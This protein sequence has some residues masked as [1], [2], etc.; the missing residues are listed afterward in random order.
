[1]A[2][3]EGSVN[4]EL[5]AWVKVHTTRGE[6]IECLVDTGFNGALMVPRE[7]ATEL[8]LSILGRVP[9][10][11][12]DSIRIIAHIAEIEIELLGRRDWADV[13]IGEAGDCLLGTQLLKDAQLV[14][15]YQAG[16]LAITR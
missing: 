14:I 12:V 7:I 6:L 1:M 3:E 13:I 2:R 4:A 5:E 8:G 11:T 9:L 10:V 15:D 16:T